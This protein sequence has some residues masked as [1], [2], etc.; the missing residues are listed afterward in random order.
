MV[1]THR[2]PRHNRPPQGCHDS[3]VLSLWIL[4]LGG[5]LAASLWGVLSALV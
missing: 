4:V 2:P 1:Q 5:G 3:L